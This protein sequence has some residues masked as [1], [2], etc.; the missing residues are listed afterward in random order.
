M[1]SQEANVELLAVDGIR[2]VGPQQFTVSCREI[3]KDLLGVFDGQHA[4]LTLAR[5]YGYS[6]N[7]TRGLAPTVV[8]SA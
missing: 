4:E 6:A 7:D 1:T 3:G 8:R 5:E 2:S